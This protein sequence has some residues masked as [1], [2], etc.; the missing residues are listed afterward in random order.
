MEKLR[1]SENEAYKYLRKKSMDY[2]ISMDV[3]AEKIIKKYG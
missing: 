1:V 2:C 3:L